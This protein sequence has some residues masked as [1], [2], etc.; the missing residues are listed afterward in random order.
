MIGS[1]QLEGKTINIETDYNAIDGR[2]YRFVQSDTKKEL[3]VTSYRGIELP[4]GSPYTK[5]ELQ[6]GLESVRRKARR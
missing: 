1:F 2:I 4:D 5:V 3:A 6:R